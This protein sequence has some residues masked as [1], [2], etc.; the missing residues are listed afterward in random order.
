MAAKKPTEYEI[1]QV[2]LRAFEILAGWGVQIPSTDDKRIPE[3]KLWNLEDRM[4]YA[5]RLSAWALK[6]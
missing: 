1:A 5:A 2:R 3:L 6:P 4:K